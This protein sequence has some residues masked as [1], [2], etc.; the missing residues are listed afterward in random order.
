[1]PVTPAYTPLLERSA[2]DVIGIDSR[3]TLTVSQFLDRVSKTA[4]GLPDQG[5]A[6]NLCGDRLNFLVGFCAAIV[7]GQC[8]LLLPN[9]RAQTQ[10]WVKQRYPDSYVLHDGV[11]VIEF[12]ADHDLRSLP[13]G[14][15]DETVPQIALEH[16]CALAF[17][18]G[19]TGES[20][21]VPKNWRTIWESAEINRL[22]YLEDLNRDWQL[23]AT[24]PAQHM[25]GLESSIFMPL[26]ARVSIHPGRPLYPVDVATDLAMLPEPRVLITTPVHMRALLASDIDF[27]GVDL[28]VSATAPLDPA[29]ARSMEARFGGVLREVYGCSEAGSLAVRRTAEE[30]DWR[31]VD[32]FQVDVREDGATVI[33][34][35]HLPE[36]V[37]LQDVIQWL[38]GHRFRLAGRSA[39]LINIA[40]KRGSLAELNRLLLALPGVEDGVI[41]EPPET[42]GVTRL[43]AL[44]V[45]PGCEQK[46]LSR[47][48]RENLDPAF[49]PRPLLLVDALPRG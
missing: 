42:G 39:D 16:V 48:L 49:V 2:N 40:G 18:S 9:G 22:S 44:V 7:R 8:N 5:H 4:R 35:A 26:R 23:L 34:A 30:Q 38:D 37:E 10:H 28:I 21:A 3:S 47:A 6:I 32:G 36:P 45:A 41:F 33:S 31:L 29:V 14:P 27:P 1:L 17:T 12:C 13:D 20:T 15:G 25:Y 19:S 46:D 11:E 24:V 43:A